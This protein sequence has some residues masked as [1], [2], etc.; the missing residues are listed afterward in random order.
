MH[1]PWSGGSLN[2]VPPTRTGPGRSVPWPWEWTVPSPAPRQVPSGGARREASTA[3][4]GTQDDTGRPA[5]TGLLS[6]IRNS[7]Q[8]TNSAELLDCGHVGQ[9][10]GVCQ[11]EQCGKKLCQQCCQS[12]TA[13]GRVLCPAHQVAVDTQLICCPADAKTYVAKRVALRLLGRD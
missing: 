7:D 9:F 2:P 11:F 8:G 3:G 13:C 1:N 5:E 10:A 6:F 4:A 12:C